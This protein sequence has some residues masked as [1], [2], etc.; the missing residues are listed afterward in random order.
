M[1][2]D[3]SNLDRPKLN[4]SGDDPDFPPF[5]EEL[6]PNENPVETFSRAEVLLSHPA[7]PE[8]FVRHEGVPAHDQDVLKRCRISLIGAGGL[9]GWTALGLVRSGAT[10]VTIIDD[11]RVDR[12]NLSRQFFLDNDLGHVKGVQLAR[13]IAGHAMAGGTVTGVG[14]NFADAMERYPLPADVF[15]AGVDNNECRLQ[16]VREARRRQI[17]AVFTMLST[18]GMRCQSFLQGSRRPGPCLWCALPNLDPEKIMPC[19]SAI[20]TSCYLAASFA[21]Y[22]THRAIMGWGNLKPFNW[23]EAD[24]SGM[25]PDRTGFVQK[26]QDCPICRE[27]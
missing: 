10:M 18:D 15:V 11:D 27:L 6:L 22:F 20:V 19:A 16:V 21:I 3:I 23:R 17:P 12:S 7:E 5:P 2:T 25:T 9:N 14:L 24:L 8:L 1:S 13:N 26:R 4:G